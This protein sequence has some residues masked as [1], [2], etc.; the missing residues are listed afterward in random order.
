[1]KDT[2]IE[3]EAVLICPRCGFAKRESMPPDT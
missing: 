3:F 1:M 2:K